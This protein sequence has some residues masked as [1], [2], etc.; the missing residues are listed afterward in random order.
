[1]SAL[2]EGLNRVLSDI[3]NTT[4]GVAV[5]GGGDSVALLHMLA[6]RGEGLRAVTV[7][8]GLRD[9]SASEAAQVSSLCED[10]G[11]PH[12]VLKWQNWDKSGNLQDEARKARL[13]LITAW[14]AEE[15]LTHVAMGHTLDDQAE[16]VLLR[17]A[18]GSGVDGLS[19]MAAFRTTGPLTWVRPLLHARRDELRAYL[20]KNGVDWIDDPSNDDP[21]YDRIKA[22][23]AF[24]IL[25]D[26]GI[27]PDGLVATANRM[28]DARMALEAATLALA[29]RCVEITDAGEV[30]LEMA[31]FNTAP[32]ELRFRLLSATLQWIS[33]APYRPRFDSLRGV[34]AR[35]STETG[36]T[37]HGCVV[38]SH[39]GNIIVRREVSKVEPSC[40][41]DAVWDHRW[42][43]T[44]RGDE[45]AEA[46]AALGEDGL[47]ECKNWR[48]T[49]HA[50]EVLLA[51][52]AVW[53][54]GQLVAAPLAGMANGWAIGLKYGKK[55]L[56]KSLMTR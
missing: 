42:V 7:D 43:T 23:Q 52:P 21:K 8:H 54:N 25:A 48:D 49:G 6:A 53:N 34:L 40:P 37:L 16:T 5:S 55:G 26:L 41:I 20:V 15:K 31:S 36:Q 35:I 4:L 11:I 45:P 17:L 33:G 14:A 38:R 9:E 10:L 18:R 19:G 24:A 13:R 1:L 2:T 39:S 29:D 27:T 32:D 44:E 3:P 46:I 50:R 51:S 47:R 22:R 12:S 30:R 28:Q 56:H